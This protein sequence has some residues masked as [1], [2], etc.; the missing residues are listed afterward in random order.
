MTTAPAVRT[1]S[2]KAPRA[3]EELVEAKVREFILHRPEALLEA[4]EDVMLG[5]LI[6][7]GAGSGPASP[8]RIQQRLRRGRK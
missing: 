8:E 4:L 7:E 3:L 2:R 1:R 5:R 6:E